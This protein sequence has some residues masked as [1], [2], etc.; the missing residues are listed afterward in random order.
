[1]PLRVLTSTLV[2]VGLGLVFWLPFLFRAPA[3][4]A[5][6]ADLKAHAVKL[7]GYT[8][9]T[10]AVWVAVALGAVL[11]VLR[12]RH[13]LAQREREMLKGLVEGSLEDHAPG[14]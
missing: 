2:V 12:E 14:E 3:E 4:T 13:K 7:A 10:V 9:L 8:M 5:T 6:Q 11:I 1:M